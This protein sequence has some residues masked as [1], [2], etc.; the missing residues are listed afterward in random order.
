MKSQFKIRSI[1]PQYVTVNVT[2][3]IRKETEGWDEVHDSIGSLHAEVRDCGSEASCEVHGRGD[4]TSPGDDVTRQ[5]KVGKKG[6]WKLADPSSLRQV[7]AS[8][9]LMCL[10]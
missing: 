10:R 7:G 8:W 9:S 3:E 5:E 6:T 1:I 4:L 2:N